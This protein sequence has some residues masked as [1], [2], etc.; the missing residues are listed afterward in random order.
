MASA[1]NE[2]FDLYRQY[3][4][5]DYIGEAVTQT[6]H[7]IQCALLAEKE[8]FSEEVILGAFFHDVGHL[9][10]MKDTSL[11]RMG[12]LGIKEHEEVGAHYLEGI[13]FPN[14]VCEI[15]RG[16]VSAKR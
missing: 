5:S 7:M 3:G 8:G 9:L 10:G 1:V 14:S 13:G 11:N 12:D 4:E 15:V 6:Q 16:H 2:L